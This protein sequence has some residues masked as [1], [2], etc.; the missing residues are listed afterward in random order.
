MPIDGDPRPIQIPE[1]LLPSKVAILSGSP[2]PQLRNRVAE[3]LFAPKSIGESRDVVT[4]YDNGEERVGIRTD[5]WGKDVFI[6][7]SMHPLEAS[8]Y[9]QELYMM[10]RGVGKRSPRSVTAVIPYFPYSRQDRE[11]QPGDVSG[12]AEVADIVGN[13]HGANIVGLNIHAEQSKE[14][15]RGTWLNPY[16]SSVLVPA[17]RELQIPELIVAAPDVGAIKSTRAVGKL[18]GAVN[19]NPFIVLKGREDE[20][21][22]QSE[23]TGFLQEDIDLKDM[24]VVLVDDVIDTA[25]TLTQAA[26]AVAARGAARIIAMAAHGSFV[27]E[28]YEKIN[29]SPIDIVYV[30]NSI[31][32]ERSRSEPKI[33]VVSIAKLLAEIIRRMTTPGANIDELLESSYI[34]PGPPEFVYEAA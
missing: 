19:R 6:I 24:T 33:K 25:D 8:H 18:I 7:Q 15:I 9:C 16:G 5:V 22:D 1:I 30:T 21:K 4:R 32:Q 27:G 26:E 17:I 34:Q 13:L 11:F 14:T 20:I 10:L 29:N 28:A 2:H 12:A 31:D 23:I 3:L